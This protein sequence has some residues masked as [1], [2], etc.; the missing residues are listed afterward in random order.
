[1]SDTS[2]LDAL[3]G[4][5][6][7]W[8]WSCPPGTDLDDRDACRAANPS[9]AAGPEGRPWALNEE[10]IYEVERHLLT[11]EGEFARER[12]GIFPDEDDEPQWL[13]VTEPQYLACEPHLEDG[14][15]LPADLAGWL[16]APIAIAVELTQDRETIT[17]VA[18]GQTA[19]GPGAQVLMREPNCPPT[20]DAIA[21][22]VAA[23]PQITTV[24]VD[25]GS[26]AG[27][28]VPDLEARGLTVVECTTKELV[29]ATG[30]TLDAIRTKA[31]RLRRSP[32]LDAAVASAVAKKRGDTELLDRWAGADPT[33]FIGVVLARW[34]MAQAPAGVAEP[35]FIVI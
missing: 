3:G 22:L 6:A 29:K 27:S 35:D 32:E 14:A 16:Q 2:G 24:V 15:P 13:V 18:A 10:W 9:L 30:S 21:A 19:D 23:D 33:P 26:Q 17:V 4:S 7:Y 1:M 12:F 34:G 28:L 31:I 8:E 5:L 11:G 20:L 25:A